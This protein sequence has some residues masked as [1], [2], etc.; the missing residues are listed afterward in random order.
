METAKA[1]LNKLKSKDKAKS[2]K[3]KEATS[4]VKEGPKTPG[5]EEVLSNVTKEKAAAAKLYIE[6][7][8]KMQM[9]SLQERKERY[10]FIYMFF[11]YVIFL[12][13]LE[14]FQWWLFFFFGVCI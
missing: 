9:Q 6:N 10:G 5:G 11:H 7:H 8:Y 2:S 3:K 13:C 14:R 12:S 4:N 1:W